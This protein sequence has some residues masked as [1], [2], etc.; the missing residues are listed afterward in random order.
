MNEEGEWQTA[1]APASQIAARAT[2]LAGVGTWLWESGTDRIT[3]SP[4]CSTLFGIEHSD[5]VSREAVLELIHPD[6]RMAVSH[7]LD[8]A[9]RGAGG[10]DREFCVVRPDGA[11]HW[12]RGKGAADLQAAAIAGIFINIDE[13][14]RTEREADLLAAIVGSSDD[15]II[16]KTLDGIVTSWNIGAERIFGYRADEMIGRS[17]SVLAAPD[18]VDEMPQILQRIRA[19]ERIEH[20][21]TERRRKDGRIVQVSLTV[22]LIHDEQGRVIGASKVARDTTG[23]KQAQAELLQQRA[24]LQSILDTVP[25]AMVVTDER[26]IVQS[27]SAAAERM[28]GYRADEVCG[29]NVSM[30]MPSPYQEQHD[31]YI[32][33]YLATGER[34]IIG[35][36]RLV[37]GQRK[38]GSTFPMELA[39]GEVQGE[40]RLFTGFVRDIS[41]RQRIRSRVQELQSEL[42][43]VSRLTEMGQMASAL[44]HELNQPLTATAN[45]LQ[46]ARRLGERRDDGSLDRAFA[47]MDGAAAQVT[48]AS[49]IIRRLR[50]F[51]KKSDSSQ[52]PEDTATL[53]EEASAL[54]LIGAKERD[55]RVGFRTS[56]ELPPVL[57]DK[58]QIQQVL[59]NLMR[60]AVEAME[61][62]IRRELLIETAPSE[63]MIVI[64][65]IDT[66]PGLA[67]EVAD[68]LFQPFVTTKAQGMG[69]GLSICRAIVEAHGGRLWN[70]AN[71]D[72]GT[73]FRFTVPAAR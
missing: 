6:D 14:M 21:E 20:F 43:H 66:G 61:A 26:G 45:Y 51:V 25:D 70:E 65:V 39:V 47:A 27:F 22:S 3:W 68:R 44:A 35:I 36:G 10:F 38:D 46:A 59:V 50:G 60:N 9:L 48:R 62:S 2:V 12:L 5:V 64:S 16:S 69:V 71:P 30:L 4:Q 40:H 73:I 49:D 41:E 15:A 18:R 8:S 29:R 72:G 56:R 67:P 37:A 33:R 63:G 31:S 32:A 7:A 55:V 53:V 24:H 1:S 13:H 57:I 34:R 58:V 23:A 54:A 28:F 52:Q 11:T 17:I 42:S 19:G